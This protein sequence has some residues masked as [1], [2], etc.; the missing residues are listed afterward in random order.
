MALT[1]N[2]QSNT[3]GIPNRAQG[4]V[5]TDSGAAAAT[6]FTVGFLPRYICWVEATDRITLEWYD[7]MAAAVAAGACIRTVA[8]GSR[9][10]DT[11]NWITVGTTALN[12]QGQF[13]IPVGDIPA[14]RT[15]YWIAEG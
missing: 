7:G 9:T 5:I 11:S 2:T 3:M 14:S 12:T 10:L 13:T 4:V 8:V 6:T 1:T 15:F